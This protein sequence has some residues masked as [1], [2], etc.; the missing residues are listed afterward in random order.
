[1]KRSEN[2]IVRFLQ[3]TI[4]KENLITQVPLLH[5]TVL[6]D[7][8]LGPQ[9]TLQAKYRS[10]KGMVEFSS[11]AYEQTQT[12]PVFCELFVF[13]LS[14]GSRFFRLFS[15]VQTHIAPTT[16]PSSVFWVDSE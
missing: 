5:N 16:C 7:V 6:V 14:Q 13:S 10:A 9:R 8:T 15:R 3:F 4:E 11:I 1:M 12:E 2:N